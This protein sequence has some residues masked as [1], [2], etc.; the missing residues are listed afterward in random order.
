MRVLQ[1]KIFKEK[2]NSKYYCRWCAIVYSSSNLNET[3]SNSCFLCNF[4]ILYKFIPH[5]PTSSY[6]PKS[7]YIFLN[8]NINAFH[9]NGWN[10][11]AN[12]HYNEKRKTCLRVKLTSYE[13]FHFSF[14]F[15]LQLLNIWKFWVLYSQI[16]NFFQI[17]FYETCIW[18]CVFFMFLKSFLSMTFFSF[19][20]N[21]FYACFFNPS[22][23][24]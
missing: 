18:S 7:T 6:Y 9:I 12:P 1:Y 11:D 10:Y 14:S 5:S 17:Q 2:K 23:R 8:L 21:M 15:L 24:L 22:R 19:T 3:S 16:G 13:L 4:N 20:L